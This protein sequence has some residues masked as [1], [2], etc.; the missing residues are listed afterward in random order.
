[1]SEELTHSEEDAGFE[2]PKTG[3]ET[4]HN[5]LPPL[6]DVEHTTDDRLNQILR[7]NV[8][9]QSFWEKQVGAWRDYHDGDLD[10]SKKQLAQ[11]QNMVE[12]AKRECEKRNINTTMM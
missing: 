3:G 6:D 5:I 1:M 12:R 9:L 4:E 2:A 11:A 8:D 10:F 7:D